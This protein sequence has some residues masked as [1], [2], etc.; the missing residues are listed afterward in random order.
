MTMFAES[1]PGG[2]DSAEYFQEAKSNSPPTRGNWLIRTVDWVGYV[3]QYTSIAVDSLDRSHISYYDLTNRDL[4]YS[5]W[6]GTAWVRETV[7]S[8]DGV[9]RFTSIDLDRDQRPHICYYDSTNCKVK[10]A[11]ND[12]VQWQIETLDSPNKEGRYTSLALDSC[13]RPHISYYDDTNEDLRY[14]YHDGTRWHTETVDSWGDVGEFASIAVDSTDRPHIVYL[15]DTTNG[16]L[17]YAYNDGVQ[18]HN[19]TVYSNGSGENYN[20]IALDSSDMPH[21]CFFDTD[22]LT[23]EYAFFDGVDWTIETVDHKENAGDH[24]S[25]ALDADDRPHVSYYDGSDNDLK[26]ACKNGVEWTIVT[27]DPQGDVGEYASLVLDSHDMPCISYH[28][29]S[30]KDLICAMMDDTLPVLEEDLTQGIPTTGDPFPIHVNVSDNKG[31]ADVKVRYTFNGADHYRVSMNPSEGGL[32]EYTISIPTDATYLSYSFIISDEAQNYF[33]SNSVDFTVLDDD[34]PAAS[35][36]NDVVIDQHETVVFNAENSTDNVIIEHYNWTF[37]YSGEE[38]RLY[39]RLADFTF[40]M[41]GMYNVTLNVTDGAANRAADHLNVS[42]LDITGP[43]AVMRF[44]DVLNESEVLVLDGTESS[45]NVGIINYTWSFLYDGKIIFLYGRVVNFTFDIIDSYNITLEVLD[46]AGLRDIAF[47]NVSVIDVTPPMADA[48]ED[49]TIR[50]YRTISFGSSDSRDNV[51]IVNFT[52]TFYYDDVLNTL[53]GSSPRFRFETPGNYTIEL[54]VTDA[55]GNSAEDFFVVTAEPVIPK[56]DDDVL[57]P[58]NRTE[59]EEKETGKDY[60]RMVG[61]PLGILFG[62]CLLILLIVVVVKVAR[63]GVANKVKKEKYQK[64]YEKMYGDG[65]EKQS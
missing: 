55:E 57:P 63:K 13:D 44:M 28:D 48:G 62:V 65:S 11:F 7:D 35:A 16:S 34:D 39:G 46:E 17:K 10:Y 3:G 6:N 31:V 60:W 14:S 56:D 41:V 26:Y 1:Q 24:G 9:G 19:E 36:G 29:D 40:D 45:D 27:V 42:V 18:W 22:N 15:N 21:I 5:F 2:T 54:K 20:S 50:D 38:T 53:Y 25:I 51:G 43:V 61:I 12:S 4:K 23:L 8:T 49:V 30:S 58:D 33:S 32:W 37:R 52:W 59:D 64:E 47:R